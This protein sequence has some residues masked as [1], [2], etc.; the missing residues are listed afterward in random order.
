M[1]TF[2]KPR[3]KKRAAKLRV[4]SRS[5]SVLKH[6][7]EAKCLMKHA[8]ERGVLSPRKENT[9]DLAT[10]ERW[11]HAKPTRPPAACP[12]S[13]PWRAVAVPSR[14]EPRHRRLTP[15]H[16]PLFCHLFSLLPASTFIFV[17]NSYSCF[18]QS[19]ECVFFVLFEGTV[20]IGGVRFRFKTS[21]N[22]SGP[23]SSESFSRRRA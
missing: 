11:N 8:P 4:I 2:T 5:V 15:S 6:R 18:S 12:S 22:V 10:A 23:R 3:R 21:L 16:T 19:D 13:G 20:W 7:T 14:P 9:R 17:G 1:Q